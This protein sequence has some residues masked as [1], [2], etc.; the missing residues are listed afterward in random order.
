MEAIA[1]LALAHD[2][3][4]ELAARGVERWLRDHRARVRI[5]ERRQERHAAEARGG[6][7]DRIAVLAD[8]EAVLLGPQLRVRSA[9]G[10]QL[11]VVRA[12]L[13]DIA[14]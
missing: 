10:E 5:V 7:L 14:P 11:G 12:V 6:D 9:V 8:R 2:L 1:E 4:A 3:A 13:G